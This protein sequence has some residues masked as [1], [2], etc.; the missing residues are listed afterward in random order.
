MPIIKNIL[1]AI[2]L[3][4]LPNLAWADDYP[5][6][7]NI[8]IKHYAFYL[9]LSDDTDAIFGNAKINIL[10]KNHGTQS[11]RLDLINKTPER[12]GKGMEIDSIKMGNIPILFTHQND[13]IIINL[14]SLSLAN[15]ELVFSIK[16][17]GIPF[18]GLK[19]GPIISSNKN[20]IIP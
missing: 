20:I 17:H 1:F 15:S 7:K 5:V 2:S 13:E 11:F 14:P 12:Q 9:T 8:D 4:L 3:F 19:I 6:N 10:F 16:Y 18:D